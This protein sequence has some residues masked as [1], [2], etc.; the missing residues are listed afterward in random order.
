MAEASMER[1]WVVGQCVCVRVCQ[2]FTPKRGTPRIHLGSG[3]DH[4]LVLGTLGDGIPTGSRSGCAGLLLPLAV[5]GASRQ[6]LPDHA[7]RPRAGV[8]LGDPGAHQGYHRLWEESSGS[9][10][11]G[12]GSTE[13]QECPCTLGLH[14]PRFIF[15]QQ[16]DP[17]PQEGTTRALSTHIRQQNSCWEQRPMRAMPGGQER[18]EQNPPRR[19]QSWADARTGGSPAGHGERRRL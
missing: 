10:C 3:N 5:L 15:L 16:L 9:A 12:Q 8:L 4:H 7:A 11:P 14:I 13:G 1:G 6:H 19:S 17:E 18:W 2:E